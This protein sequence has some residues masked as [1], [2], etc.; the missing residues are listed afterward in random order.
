M[1]NILKK[2]K[3]IS[4]ITILFITNFVVLI[5]PAKALLPV[6]CTNCATIFTQMMEYAEAAN[7][8]FNT[9]KQL[10]TQIQQY[11]DMV[12]QGIKLDPLDIEGMWNSLEL[13]N[14]AYEDGKSL[15]YNMKDLNSKFKKLYPGYENYLK[16]VGKINPT[17]DYRRWAETGFSNARI[18]IQAAGINTSSFDDENKLMRRLINR[19]ANA[20]GR[21]QAIQAGNEIATQQVKQMQMLRELMANNITL[22]AN[23]TANEVERRA[24]NEADV[25]KFFET[26]IPSTDR[27]HE[28]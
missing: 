6:T 18:A 13:L 28:F 2:L 23:Y 5:V 22:Q 14:K 26:K 24:K 3:F 20:K 11:K 7:T 19:S 1:K 8:A 27:G 17:E 15:A 21:M 12:Q 4:V 9:A 10:Q 25:E 16:N